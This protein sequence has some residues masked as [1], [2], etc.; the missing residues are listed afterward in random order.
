MRTRDRLRA[1]REAEDAIAACEASA[2][3]HGPH[4]T[5]DRA[6][7]HWRRVLERLAATEEQSA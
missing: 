1:L 3:E 7:A 2:A 6:I 4:P 5:L